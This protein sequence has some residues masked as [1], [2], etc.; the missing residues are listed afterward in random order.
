MACRTC[1][2]SAALSRAVHSPEDRTQQ[3]PP[4]IVRKS[5]GGRKFPV[6]KIGHRE[7]QNQPTAALKP[8][9]HEFIRIEI[10]GN[11]LRLTKAKRR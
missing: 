3:L 4:R 9:G 1:H 7:I 6:F 11:T 10:E 2:R 8:L 5:G